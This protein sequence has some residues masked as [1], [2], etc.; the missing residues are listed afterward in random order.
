LLE[1]LNENNI[2]YH[3]NG[4]EASNHG[5]IVNIAFPWVKND[6]LLANLD[7]ENIAI[8]SGSACTAGAIE[9]SH[10]LVSMYGKD[11]ERIHHSVRISFGHHN[12]IDEVEVL[13][14]VLKKLYDKLG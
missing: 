2:P 8:S 10:V 9:P 1:G 4:D 3:V 6:I 11:D 7:L 13:I 12:T 14:Q 5:Y